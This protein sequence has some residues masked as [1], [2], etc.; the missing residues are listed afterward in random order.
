MTRAKNLRRRDCVVP[1]NAGRRVCDVGVG[2]GR[3]ACLPVVGKAVIEMAT[4]EGNDGVGSAECPEHAGLLETRADDSLASGFDDTGADKE[5]L[6]SK[7]GVAHALGVSL[8]VI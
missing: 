8:E 4:A 2:S 6:R 3:A 1:R 7:L 5:V